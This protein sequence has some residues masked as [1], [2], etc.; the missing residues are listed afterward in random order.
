MGQS[1]FLYFDVTLYDVMVLE[2]SLMSVCF[3]HIPYLLLDS[4]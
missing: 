4:S 2:L 1:L 3:F